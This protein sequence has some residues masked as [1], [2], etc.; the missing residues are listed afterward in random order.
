MVE[1]RDAENAR[2]ARLG[3]PAARIA[4]Q[5]QRA[6]SSAVIRPVP[7]GNFVTAGEEPRD[8]DRFLVRLGAAVGEKESVDV[9]GCELGELYTQ[10]STHLSG[11]KRVGISEC[12]G[13]LLDGA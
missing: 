1:I 12:R 13:L 5:R 10:S 4:G 9:T 3:R 11:H 2:D 8:A 6:R 7:R